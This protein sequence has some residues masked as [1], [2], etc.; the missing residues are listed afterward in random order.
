MIEVEEEPLFVSVPGI[1][2]HVELMSQGKFMAGCPEQGEQSFLFS[3]YS[4]LSESQLNDQDG[5][6]A[7][8]SGC[9]HTVK[10]QQSDFFALYV[11]SFNHSMSID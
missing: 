5:K 11:C 1:D 10:R 6:C 4:E 8:P 9:G 2:E 7:C 3:L